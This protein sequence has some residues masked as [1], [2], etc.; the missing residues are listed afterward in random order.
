[1]NPNIGPGTE[2]G[3]NST[4]CDGTGIPLY[5]YHEDNEGCQAYD[6]NGS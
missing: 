4:D 3:F 2:V 5:Y 1:M 6:S